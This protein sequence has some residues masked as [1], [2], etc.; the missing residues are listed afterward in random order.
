MA[1]RLFAEVTFKLDYL[2][3]EDSPQALGWADPILQVLDRAGVLGLHKFLPYRHWFR[4]E[5]GESIREIL[6]DRSTLD[7]P[8]WDGSALERIV[9]MHLA[10]RANF[11]REIDAALSLEAAHRV[12]LKAPTPAGEPLDEA[13]ELSLTER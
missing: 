13:A 2:H 10:G 7:L 11:V 5:A 6:T 8:W 4:Q 1:R 3:R 9:E 12:L